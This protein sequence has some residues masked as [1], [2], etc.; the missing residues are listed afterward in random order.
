MRSSWI[1]VGLKSNDTSLE[2]KKKGEETQNHRRE[3]HCRWGQVRMLVCKSR[4]ARHCQH[5]P[6]AG[7]AGNLQ[8]VPTLPTPSL[9]MSGPRTRREY[10][11]VVLNFQVCGVC[12]GSSRSINSWHQLMTLPFTVCSYQHL[13]NLGSGNFLVEINSGRCNNRFAVV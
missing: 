4:E 11:S 2:E 5:P 7:E 1:M 10:V 6:E 9:G 3:H 12:Y 8:K 13:Q